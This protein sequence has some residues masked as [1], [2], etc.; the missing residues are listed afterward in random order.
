MYFFI[1]PNFEINFDIVHILSRS[2][3][4]HEKQPRS[5]DIPNFYIHAT[6]LANIV[7]E[8]FCCD[9]EQTHDDSKINRILVVDP[10]NPKFL[11]N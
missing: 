5:E 4:H 1:T 10:R 9:T 11:K 3:I 6:F 7:N 2:R 8:I